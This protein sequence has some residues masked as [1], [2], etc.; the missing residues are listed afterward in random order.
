MTT[1]QRLTAVRDALTPLTNNVYHYWRPQMSAPFIVWQETGEGDSFSSDNKK[2]EQLITGT[3]DLY[4]KTEF[5]PLIDQIQDALRSVDNLGW[6][7]T[8]A[9]YE[10]ETGLIHHSWEF[11]IT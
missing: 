10:D 7:L 9:V 4:S 5:D 1:I 2:S 3:V 6:Q 11:S 8:D